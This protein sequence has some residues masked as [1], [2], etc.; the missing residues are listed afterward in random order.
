[1]QAVCS[2]SATGIKGLSVARSSGQLHHLKWLDLLPCCLAPVNL[3]SAVS[4]CYWA[5]E[6]CLVVVLQAEP[7]GPAQMVSAVDVLF[8]LTGVC[9]FM[10]VDPALTSLLSCSPCR[11][12]G[13]GQQDASSSSSSLLDVFDRGSPCFGPGAYLC[14]FS[15]FEIS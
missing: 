13:S 11:V 14:S 5:P 12:Q 8:V 1:M 9:V 4:C 10:V 6:N 3:A 15:L 7:H 2:T